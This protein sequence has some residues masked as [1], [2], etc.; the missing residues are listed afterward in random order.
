MNMKRILYI[1]YILVLL[2]SIQSCDRAH[3]LFDD[4]STQQKEQTNVHNDDSVSQNVPANAIEIQSQLQ[5]RDSTI[6]VLADSLNNLKTNI[7]ELETNIK[8]LNKNQEQ[9]QNEKVGMKSLFVYLLIFTICLIVLVMLLVKKLIKNSSLNEEK[10]KGIIEELAQ[11]HPEIF[12]GMINR[13]LDA[14]HL[15]ITTLSD[16]IKSL[17]NQLS[18][19]KNQMSFNSVNVNNNS[20]EPKMKP[21][22]LPTAGNSSKNTVFYMKRPLANMEFELSLKSNIPTEETLYRFE[23]DL[24]HPDKAQFEFFCTSK[25]RIRWAW[26]SKENTLDRVCNVA[27]DGNLGKAQTTSPGTAE[28]RN[29]KWI[30]TRKAVVI[31]N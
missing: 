14:H 3:S 13:T 20:Q 11:K 2:I 29:G 22:S 28:L 27:G 7:S 17:N 4:N 1:V 8:A 15:R 25:A 12:C 24:K 30:V 19:L 9:L 5:Q 31:F 23:I 16:S 21:S 26:A 6:K 10:V 18:S